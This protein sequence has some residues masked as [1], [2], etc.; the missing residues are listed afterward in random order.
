M[1]PV[2]AVFTVAMMA[3]IG[4][5]GLNGFVG[6]FLILITPLSLGGRTVNATAQADWGIV[7]ALMIVIV[8]IGIMVDVAFTRVDTSVRRRYGLVDASIR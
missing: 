6:E 1:I 7:V 8:F 3:S 5:P 4:L 2:A